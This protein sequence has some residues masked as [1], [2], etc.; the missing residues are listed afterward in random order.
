MSISPCL[1]NNR[2][3]VSSDNYRDK[4]LSLRERTEEIPDVHF[5][6]AV[7]NQ[8]PIY[9]S[10]TRCISATQVQRES[11]RIQYQNE[12]GQRVELQANFPFHVHANFVSLSES[13][14]VIC[15]QAPKED[16]L[17]DFWKAVHKHTRFIV[18]LTNLND[19]IFYY[20]PLKKDE[21]LQFE[22]ISVQALGETEDSLFKYSVNRIHANPE[23]SVEVQRLH[24]SDWPDRGTISAVELK[25]LVDRIN[26]LVKNT[27]LW[28]HCRAG[29]G[30]TGTLTVALA[31]DEMH[32]KG[33]LI[34]SQLTEQIDELILSGRKQR[35]I[36]FVH[37]KE[38][39]QLLHEF[40]Q[41]ISEE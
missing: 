10:G 34:P 14:K 38:Q 29:V 2:V 23:E 33:Q 35:D 3:S 26:H 19:N 11:G 24:F 1:F 31:L 12:E 36:G 8:F 27:T 5:N 41:L 40:A 13:V 22:K 37:T 17:E 15:S 18:D 28:I 6:F 30:R 39:Y 9:S 21:Q 16:N 20:Y 4:F 7:P 25:Q 32:R